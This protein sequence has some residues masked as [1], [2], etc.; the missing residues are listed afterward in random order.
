[1]FVY[2]I[3]YIVIYFSADS[4]VACATADARSPVGCIQLFIGYIYSI[5]IA[6]AQ[7][8]D[9]YARSTKTI[10]IFISPCTRITSVTRSVSHTRIAESACRPAPGSRPHPHCRL[11]THKAKPKAKPQ[12][13][14]L[15]LPLAPL[16]LDS[17]GQCHA[18]G[19]RAQG[20]CSWPCASARSRTCT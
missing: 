4:S 11:Y 17:S 16:A 18:P 6:P 15:A 2:S 10:T 20:R 14:L 7:V 1:M 9:E 12:P 3:A 5:Y 8:H 13:K 19:H